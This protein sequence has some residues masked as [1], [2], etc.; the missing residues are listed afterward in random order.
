MWYIIK[1]D[2]YK[3]QAAIRDLLRIPCVKDIYFPSPRLGIKGG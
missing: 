3:E 1:T 2:F